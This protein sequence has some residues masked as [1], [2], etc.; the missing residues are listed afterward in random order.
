MTPI[1]VPG[2][3][4]FR[5]QGGFTLLEILVVLLVVGIVAATV[6]IG[7]SPGDRQ[8]TEIEASRLADLFEEAASEASSRDETLGWS[9]NDNVYIFW[10]KAEDGTWNEIEGDDLFRRHALRGDVRIGG[11]DGVLAPEKKIVFDPSGIN[12]PFT[13]SLSGNH[14]KAD[15][16]FDAMNRVTVDYH[17]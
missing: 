14:S 16:S 17:E 4:D 8:E 5:L 10:K 11:I 2:A 1:S 15:I 6:A 3:S 13:I 7:I 9:G 12:K